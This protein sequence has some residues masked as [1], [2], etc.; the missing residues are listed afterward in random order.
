MKRY[1]VFVS[2]FVAIVACGGNNGNNGDDDDGNADANNGS[3]SGSQMG[4]GSNVATGAPYAIPLTTPDE[5]FW[6]PT[7]TIGGVGFVMDL[8]T[9]S[10][11]TGVAGSTCSNC[12]VSPEYTPG[13]GATDTGQTA[14]T[15]YEDDSGWSGEIYTDTIALENGSPN[16]TLNIVDITAQMFA[17]DDPTYG[18]FDGNVYQGI[19]GMGPPA[20]AEPNTGA[21]FDTITQAGVPAEMAFELCDSGG[22]MWLGGFDAS[23]ASGAPAYTPMDGSDQYFYSIDPAS[24]ALGGSNLAGKTAADFQ[25]W[26][27]DTGTTFFYLPTKVE[28]N[29]I[30]A[31]NNNA[32][33]KTLFPGTTLKDDPDGSGVGCTANSSVTDAQVESMLPPF[34]MT[35]PAA[36]GGSNVTVSATPLKSY[37]YDQGSGS[38]CLGVGNG[39]NGAGATTMG[40]QIMQ[41]FVTVIDLQHNQIGWATDSGCNEPRRP[42]DRTTFRP[43]LP[44]PH[45]LGN[46]HH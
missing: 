18:F 12:S 21:Y 25:D 40:D 39:G 5:S 13:A 38:F 34:Q 36:G 35:L 23:H 8:D 14:T 41:A 1:S 11:S 7:L 17:T 28:S 20:N 9:G 2:C 31:L 30:T 46:R 16:A 26:V 44:K 29:L 19:L 15:Q 32:S 43:H 27:V 24:V 45:H 22:T 3:G 33:F 10:T 42:R 6:A 4:S 37:L